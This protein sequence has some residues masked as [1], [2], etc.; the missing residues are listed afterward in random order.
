MKNVILFDLDGTVTDPKEGITKSVQYALSHFDI[1]IEDPD[2]LCNF[3]GPPLRESFK[4]FFGF[5]DEDAELATAKYR[6]RF[7]E[8]GIYKNEIYEGMEDLL[9]NLKDSGKTLILATS[10]P[11]VFAEHILQHFG[12][13]KYF[14]FICGSELSGERSD[15]YEIIKYAIEKNGI[16]DAGSCIMIGDRKFDIIGAKAAGVSN[17]GVLYGYGSEDELSEAGADYLVRDVR[18]LE[19]L[20][21]NADGA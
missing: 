7:T 14:S 2:E 10:K 20:L 5:N 15:K 16:R 13:D 9:K 6:E 12:I 1:H 11:T 4:E 18:E 21:L 17:I 8:S 19:K 3:I